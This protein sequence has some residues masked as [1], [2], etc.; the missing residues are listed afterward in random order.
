MKILLVH[1]VYQQR[2][3]EEAVV[4][5]EARLLEA[6]GHAVVRYERNNDELQGRGALSG[7]GAAVET[8]WSS[9]AFREMAAVIGKERPDVAPFANTF[10][11]IFPSTYYPMPGVVVPV[12]RT[13]A[14]YA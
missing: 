10:S 7:I 2:A 4:R 1:N 13:T 5:A 11:L 8:I 9:R 3:G 12:A 6:N 14:T